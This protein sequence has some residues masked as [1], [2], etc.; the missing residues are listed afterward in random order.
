M[1]E[2]RLKLLF[3]ATAL[4]TAPARAMDAIDNS[5]PPAIRTQT[6]SAPPPISDHPPN[7]TP[8][9]R[10]M[11]P[12]NAAAEASDNSVESF[13]QVN[14][15]QRPATEQK[16]TANPNRLLS[17]SALTTGKVLFHIL[18]FMGVPIFFCWGSD[19]DPDLAKGPV[20]ASPKL[21]R[22]SMDTRSEQPQSSKSA[23]MTEQAIPHKIPQSE[24][25][26]TIYEPQAKD[27]NQ[28]I[29]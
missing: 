10:G 19:L 14:Q 2:H 4:A 28:P 8:V 16:S 3:L 21:Q 27:S 29:K 7:D 5:A 25:E 1:A 11:I 9:L 13:F 26:G 22:Q 23:P 24:L 12:V 17:D 20:L 6:Q 15:K 18:D